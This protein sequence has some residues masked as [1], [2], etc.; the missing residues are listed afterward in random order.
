MK[1]LAALCCL[2]L[3]LALPGTPARADAEDEMKGSSSTTPS[4]TSAMTSTTASP[5]AC[6]PR[7]AWIST[8]WCANAPTPVGAAW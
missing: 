2:C 8:W 4:R 1:P 6:A 7:A 3:L 5:T